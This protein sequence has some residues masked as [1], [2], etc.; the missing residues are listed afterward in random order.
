MT[1]IRVR[2][3]AKLRKINNHVTSFLKLPHWPWTIIIKSMQEFV[4]YI[5]WNLLCFTNN[6][7]RERM[8]EL[9]KVDNV[10]SSVV[11]VTFNTLYSASAYT[12]SFIIVEPK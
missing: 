2:R 1:V 6:P 9:D 4:F 11:V 3:K 5:D 7:E 10:I 8:Q 12:Y